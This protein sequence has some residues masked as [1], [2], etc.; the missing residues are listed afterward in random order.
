[1]SPLRG[2]MFRMREPST[3]LHFESQDLILGAVG[4]HKE[5]LLMA[6]ILIHRQCINF[7]S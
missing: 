2:G 4:Q 1:M 5:L 7:P 3:G 6:G